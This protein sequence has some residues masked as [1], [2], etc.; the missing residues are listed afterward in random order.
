MNF[1]GV[2]QGLLN[3]QQQQNTDAQ[4]AQVMQMRALQMQQQKQTL[5]QQQKQ[6][7]D[8]DSIAALPL[9]PGWGGQA[10]NAPPPVPVAPNTQQSAPMPPQNFAPTPPMPGQ[11]SVPAQ[12]MPQRPPMPPQPQAMAPM[13]PQ[14]PARP[15]NPAQTPPPPYQSMANMVAAKQ[16]QSG[17]APM[18]P[19]PIGAPQ[20][21]A[22]QQQ[23]PQ[24]QAQGMPAPPMGNPV[25]DLIQFAQQQHLS[26]TQTA[27][28]LEKTMPIAKEIAAEQE[29]QWKM[30]QEANA[31]A[32]QAV[33]DKAEEASRIAQGKNIDSEIHH[34]EWEEKH[35]K[36]GDSGDTG[37]SVGQGRASAFK[38]GMSLGQG[39]N[40][41]A[42]A[43]AEIQ[44]E[45][46]EWTFDE[47]GQKGEQAQEL[48]K[49]RSTQRQLQGK[50]AGFEKT[51]LGNLEAIEK[52]IQ[53]QGRNGKGDMP[54]LNSL[55][56]KF[57]QATGQAYGEGVRL[58]GQEEAAEL[59]KLAS[60]ATAAGAGGTLTDREE[61][62]TFFDQ[63]MSNGQFK[64]SI[65][66][67]RQAVNIR[68]NS[69]KGAIA[70]TTQE[71]NDLWDIPS[72]GSAAATNAPKV[73]T[74]EGGYKFKGGNPADKSNWVKQ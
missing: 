2:A 37:G 15:P 26:P 20:A 64:K 6:V 10:A 4:N 28:Y 65:D 48:A 46:P 45:H 62:K 69:S 70:D 61:W 25:I 59:A 57:K 13:Q 16:P 49:E 74:I 55:L 53:E 33:K 42:M 43:I 63:T 30:L 58:F 19:P 60:S 71:L 21:P 29:R 24:G 12:P 14:Q 22:Q 39:K 27:A 44:K 32:R 56:N 31:S 1:N 5:E 11:P 34:R 17:G 3:Y 68:V 72:G 7:Q 67:A 51:A 35:P 50:V 52:E 73:G 41:R 36:G 8:A 47:I 18:G 66:S 23:A 40:Q 38:A 9:P 54:Y